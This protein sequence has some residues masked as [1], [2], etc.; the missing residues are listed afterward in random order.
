[1]IIFFI[2]VCLFLWVVISVVFP[3]IVREILSLIITIFVIIGLINIGKYIK[4]L[5]KEGKGKEV[6]GFVIVVVKT[7]I[8]L[9]VSVG[10]FYLIAYGIQNYYK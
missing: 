7:I 3:P 8:Y 10:G 4:G 6:L 9:I 2:I 5:V 1:M